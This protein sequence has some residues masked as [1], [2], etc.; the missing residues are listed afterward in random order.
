[1]N[2]NDLSL[3]II[4]GGKSSRLGTDK[5]QLK[6]GESSLLEH[7]LA[8]GRKAGFKEIFLCAEAPSPFLTELAEKYGTALLFDETQGLG[9]VSGLARGLD[10][11]TNSWA[12][13]IAGDMPF[14]DLEK[15]CRF[16]ATLPTSELA[17]LPV[18]KG[19]L[20]PLAAF[21]QRETAT[22]FQ[23]ALHGGVRKIRQVLESFP[24][25]QREYT[26]S[27]SHFFNINTPAD[28]RLAQGRFAN[29]RRKVSVISITAPASGTGKTTFIEKLLPRL[30]ERGIR[31]GVIKSDS[32]GFNLDM[33]GKDSHR[34][35]QAGAES[36]AVISPQGWFI[37]Q[38][39]DQRAGFEAIAHKMEGIDL[40]LTES[41]S[42]GT[43]PALSLWRGK[44]TPLAGEDVAAIFTSEP[45]AE[46]AAI[47]E[48]NLNDIEKAVESCLFL[49]GR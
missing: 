45:H 16:G 11:L 34:F 47:Y 44:G 17:L 32:H 13:A 8:K 2:T 15:L 43:L 9:P 40:L 23:R 31:A 26:G 35:S 36:V 29:L 3:L 27:P 42:H 7:T 22:Y 24:C 14:L 12:L 1:M 10:C 37:T 20:Q 30:R 33:E 49:M 46:A 28:W 39:T 25:S 5:R 38:K 6:L 48:Y 41:R 19:R 21:Y 4:A 18:A